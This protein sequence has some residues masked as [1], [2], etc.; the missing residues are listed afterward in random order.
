M[1]LLKARTEHIC[2]LK[3]NALGGSFTVI[4]GT[5]G[6]S[7]ALLAAIAVPNF[8][9]RPQALAGHPHPRDLRMIGL[10]AIDQYAIET[11]KTGR[12]RQLVGLR[13]LYLKQGSTL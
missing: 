5:R 6:I 12:R 11:N 1:R 9:L 13:G 3:T 2:F 4:H 7:F 10:T 8:L